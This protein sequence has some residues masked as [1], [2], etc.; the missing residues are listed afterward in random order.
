MAPV[1]ASGLIAVASPP[2]PPPPPPQPSQ[3]PV[4]QIA[5][6]TIQQQPSPQQ[7]IQEQSPISIQ[8]NSSQSNVSVTRVL[9]KWEDM[10]G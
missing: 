8:Q 2:P 1:L 6:V 7:T 3:Q 4:Q 10:K 5:T 9:G